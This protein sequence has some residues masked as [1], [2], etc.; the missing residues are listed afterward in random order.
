MKI[1]ML[2]CFVL[3]FHRLRH[4]TGFPKSHHKYQYQYKYQF[5]NTNKIHFN[6]YFMTAMLCSVIS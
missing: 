5:T 4:V 3:Q 6:I 1:T 2:I